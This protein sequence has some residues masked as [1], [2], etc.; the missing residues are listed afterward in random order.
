[1]SI[2]IDWLTKDAGKCDEVGKIDDTIAVEIEGRVRC[3]KDANKCEEVGKID[4]SAL[5]C[6]GAQEKGWINCVNGGCQ[7]DRFKW[8]ASLISR[9]EEG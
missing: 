4:Q 9:V 8:D 1:M 2:G 5:V 6:V 7:L 3:F